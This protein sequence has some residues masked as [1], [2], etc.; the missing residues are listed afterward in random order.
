MI[1]SS[2]I[3]SNKTQNIIKLFEHF[4]YSNDVNISEAVDPNLLKNLLFNFL[5]TKSFL[6]LYFDL[7]L[8]AAKS[9]NFDLTD[10]ALQE[11]PTPRV[12]LPNAH[13]TSFHC[14]YWYGH[15]NSSYTVWTP[16]TEIDSQNTFL[17]I[18]E[19]DN[20]SAYDH[21]EKNKKFVN[22]DPN[23]SKL[24]KPVLLSK[25]ESIVF[26]SKAIHGSPINSSSKIRIS[27]DFRFTKSSDPTSTK[28]LANYFHFNTT[29][30]K[31]EKKIPSNV[32][33]KFLKY[34]CGGMSRSTIMQHLTIESAAKQFN[35][36]IV[37]QE[38]EIERYGNPCLIEYLSDKNLEKPFN[39]IAIASVSMLNADLVALI[40]KSSIP[41]Y[42]ALENFFINQ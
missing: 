18:S 11:L 2:V 3:S 5:K 29:L 35:L 33:L 30:N 38:A 13:G 23:V 8:D 28:D 24:A 12:F 27:F 40:K 39:A 19:V 10:F 21:L 37:A 32:N 36:N 31:F 6:D 34:I 17:L 25:G 4:T 7:A 42:C 16:L 9:V 41:I 15:G 26:H 14:D 1:Y 22:I 20:Y